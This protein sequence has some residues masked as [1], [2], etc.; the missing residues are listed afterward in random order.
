M[1]WL[2]LVAFTLSCTQP[3]PRAQALSAWEAGQAA[4]VAED[5][6]AAVVHFDEALALDDKSPALFGW[7][8]YALA[9]GGDVIEAVASLDAG[10]THTPRDP[11]LHYNRAAYLSRLERYGDAHQ[12]LLVAFSLEPPLRDR[13]AQDRDFGALSDRVPQLFRST[14][15]TVAVSGETGSV[16]LGEPYELSLTAEVPTGESLEV[17]YAGEAVPPFRLERVIETVTKRGDKDEV[18]IRWSLFP[19]KTGEGA[20]GPWTLRAGSQGAMASA[21]PYQVV[22]A[23]TAHA[24][25]ES[26]PAAMLAPQPSRLLGA[27]KGPGVGTALVEEWVV[28]AHP[29]GVEV[30]AVS[31]LRPNGVRLESRV[32]ERIVRVGTAWRWQDEAVEA[33]LRL[34]GKTEVAIERLD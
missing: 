7:K 2:C 17:A 22:S 21:V 18:V 26:L 13:A 11:T 10:L 15:L 20:L 28:V 32:S 3:E 31:G 24:G 33:L 1:R 9:R 16:L 6:A 30:Q 25:G 27:V 29:D 8:A 12:S 14:E 23:G 4:I 34:D 19:L 5:W